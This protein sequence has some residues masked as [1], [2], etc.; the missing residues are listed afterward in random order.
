MDMIIKNRTENPKMIVPTS[1]KKHFLQSVINIGRNKKK[2]LMV[3]FIWILTSWFLLFILGIAV[4]WILTGITIC[5][6]FTATLTGKIITGLSSE[7]ME[8]QG[9][10]IG[11]LKPRLF[12]AKMIANNGGRIYPVDG[13]DYVE[14]IKELIS[15]LGN[16]TIHGL[17]LN[18]NMYN[19]FKSSFSSN[20]S[21]PIYDERIASI[22]LKQTLIRELSNTGEKL[23]YGLLVKSSLNNIYFRRYFTDNK[24]QVKSCNMFRLDSNPIGQSKDINLFTLEAGLFWPSFGVCLGALACIAGFGG[25]YESLRLQ[26]RLHLRAI[27]HIRRKERSVTDHTGYQRKWINLYKNGEEILGTNKEEN[28]TKRQLRNELSKQ[29]IS[30]LYLDHCDILL[31]DQSERKE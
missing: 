10:K 15:M 30:V 27:P 14:G 9:K 23:S 3:S 4:V 19:L 7:D 17:V 16:N 11:W 21:D 25:F 5:S 28:F 24:L 13:Y 2:L 26:L 1:K 20:K 29:G 6:L 31:F 18:K 8:M 12:E 22:F